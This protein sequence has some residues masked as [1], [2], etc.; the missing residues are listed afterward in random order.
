M[1]RHFYDDD[2]DDDDDGV[3]LRNGLPFVEGLAWS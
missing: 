2:D 1:D 3:G